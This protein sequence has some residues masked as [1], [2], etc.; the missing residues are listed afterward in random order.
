MIVETQASRNGDDFVSASGDI[1]PNYGQLK[2]M[3]VTRERTTRG[4]T[5]QAAGVAK[6]LGSV[7]RMMQTNHRVVFDDTGSYIENKHTGEVNW[8]REE[9]GNFMLD[10]WVPPPTVAKAAGFHGQP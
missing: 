2:V 8:M 9:D 7:K 6:P 3:L 4:M 5:F 1:I 10:V